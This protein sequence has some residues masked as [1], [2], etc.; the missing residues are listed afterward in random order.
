MI[1]PETQK[2][3]KFELQQ[4]TSVIPCPLQKTSDLSG[5]FFDC[6]T[7][8]TCQRWNGTERQ[9][10]DSRMRNVLF[11][12]TFGPR[13]FS[14]A[15]HQQPR[16]QAS[17]LPGALPGSTAAPSVRK[18]HHVPHCRMTAAAGGRSPCHRRGRVSQRLTTGKNSQLQRKL[19]T[20]PTCWCVPS[21]PPASCQPSPRGKAALG[22]SAPPCARC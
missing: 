6:F 3:D 2:A 10:F 8:P 4:D 11:A 1:C 13:R 14:P 22:T 20:R 17:Q 21:R 19:P 15:Q 7:S 12:G 9:K 5:G 18:L 16:N